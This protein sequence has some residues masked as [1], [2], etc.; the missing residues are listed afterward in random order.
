MIDVAMLVTNRAIDDVRVVMEANALA[1]AGGYRVTVI[2]WDREIDHD[3]IQDVGPVRFERLKLR[4]THGRGLSQVAYL[5]RFH[6]RAGRRLAELKPQVIHCHDLDTL[7]VGRRWSRRLGA[8]LVFD[9]HENFPDMMDGHLPGAAVMLLRMLEARLVRRCDLLITVGRKLQR[10]YRR[11]GARRTALVGNWKD[12]CSYDPAEIRKVRDELKLGG[13]IAIAFIA[14]LGR[15]RHLEPLLE[16]VAGDERF[17][18]VIGGQGCLESIAR[19]YSQRHPHICYLGKVAPARVALLTAACDV[20]YYGFDKNNPNS[21]WSAPNKLYEAIA[22]GKP[23]LAG[24]FGEIGLTVGH[25]GCGILAETADVD[26]LRAALDRLAQPGALQHMGA[27]ASALQ[28][29]FSARAATANLLD[30]YA[31]LLG[32]QLAAEAH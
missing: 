17:A 31:R 6:L 32:S 22:A 14:N 11:L 3:V 15:E 1:T 4:S 28:E 5:A 24:D 21:Q 18:A 10:H 26:S 30:A 2:G 27:I 12:A 23:V 29:K 8:K 20:V 7:P 13:R 19:S 16:A 25:S 9:A